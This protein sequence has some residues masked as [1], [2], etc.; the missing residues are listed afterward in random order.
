MDMPRAASSRMTPNSRALRAAWG[1]AGDG[2]G[3]WRWLAGVRPV[4]AKASAVR[5]LPQADRPG[6]D[7]GVADVDLQQAR[8][9]VVGLGQ[10][11]DVGLGGVDVLI[12]DQYHL[13]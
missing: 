1:S 7:V 9:Q 3:S 12:N 13:D 11:P 6:R 2:G 4:R 10:A 8:T 5:V